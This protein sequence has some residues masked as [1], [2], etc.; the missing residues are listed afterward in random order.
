MSIR[1]EGDR[2]WVS[3][4]ITINTGNYSSAKVD[5]G[6]TFELDEKDD[7]IEII[8]EMYTSIKHHVMEKKTE[9]LKRK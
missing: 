3:Y 4:G 1:K 2:V 8:D 6:M 7:P 5:M 9:I